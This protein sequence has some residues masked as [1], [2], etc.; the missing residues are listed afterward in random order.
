M[1]PEQARVVVDHPDE[2]LRE[3]LLNLLRSR[4]VD[5]GAPYAIT[6]ACVLLG[7]PDKYADGQ[8]PKFKS[9]LC[10]CGK[11]KAA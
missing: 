8:R 2:K 5:G 1:R 4:Y 11:R 7:H 9:D 6:T 10:P 3:A